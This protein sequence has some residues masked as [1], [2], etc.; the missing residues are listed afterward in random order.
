MCGLIGTA[1]L[2]MALPEDGGALADLILLVTLVVWVGS[3]WLLVSVYRNGR[4][5]WVVPPHL[6]DDETRRR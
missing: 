6:R 4:P 2:L 3:G 1:L 5:E